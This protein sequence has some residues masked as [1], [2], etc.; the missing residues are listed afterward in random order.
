MRVALIAEEAT[1]RRCAA[2]I[3]DR[4]DTTLV[5]LVTDDPQQRERAEPID[6][7]QVLPAAA[8]HERP[9]ADLETPDL[10]LNVHS[11]HRLGAAWLDW[12]RIGA[13]NLHPGPLPECAGLNAPSWSIWHG[14]AEHGATIHWMAETI[15]TGDLA[16]EARFPL[17]PNHTGLGVATQTARLGLDLLD[18]LL[19]HAAAHTIPRRPQDLAR[20][21]YFRAG[22]PDH[23][24]LSWDWP[25]ERIV[26]LW[27][28]SDYGPFAAPWG[29]PRIETDHGE[30]E[31]RQ[32]RDA[33]EDAAAGAD[34]AA[35]FG[36][37]GAAR[38][39]PAA[40][41][42]AVHG[43]DPRHERAFAGLWVGC[44]DGAVHVGSARRPG[45]P[46]SSAAALLDE[47]AR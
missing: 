34:A 17:Q 6:G 41:S 16:L 43:A 22:P 4:A 25:A 14:A 40:D 24:R 7:V 23:G 38:P 44:A 13:F 26:R 5:T 9:P 37:P 36:K 47:F 11:L 32:I 29:Y 19:D 28:A 35:I 31:L 1:G 30:L 33:A 20:R 10:L 45:E 42:A 46:W 2:R 8:V 27:R 21:R 3:A 15:D 12:P 39:A 18:Q